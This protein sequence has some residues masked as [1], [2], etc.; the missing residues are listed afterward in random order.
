M[1]V[2]ISSLTL[3]GM[4]YKTLRMIYTPTNVLPSYIYTPH[5]YVDKDSEVQAIAHYPHHSG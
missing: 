4:S 3:E 2:L 1:E 5:E